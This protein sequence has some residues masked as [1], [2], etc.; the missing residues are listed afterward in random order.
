MGED[1]SWYL[2]C[3]DIRD[4]KRWRKSFKLL[5]GYGESIQFSIFRCRLNRRQM[6]KLRWELER[7]LAEEDRLTLVALCDSCVD[8]MVVR[9]EEKWKTEPETFRIF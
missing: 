6:E 2:V 9:N 1:V 7:I 3:Y 8:R 5:K 4:P